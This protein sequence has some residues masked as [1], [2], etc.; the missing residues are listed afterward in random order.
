MKTC[1]AVIPAFNEKEGIGDVVAE[2]KRYVTDIIVVDDGST[3]G[4]DFLKIKEHAQVIHL[5][6]NHGKGAA[7]RRGF[8]EAL[9]KN[10]E[11]I[12]M[13][14]AD[15]EHDPTLIPALI[16]FAVGEGVDIVS[17]ARWE[18]RSDIRGILNNFMNFW[19]GIVTGYRITD[20]SCG[21]RVLK[22]EA[23]KRLEL[24]SN[25]FEIELEMLLD[26]SKRG[27]SYAEYPLKTK[28]LSESRV[29]V[30]DMIE[31]DLFF[32]K[33]VL[34]NR[35]RIRTGKHKKLFL[36]FFCI[37]GYIIFSILKEG[38]CRWRQVQQSS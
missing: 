14:D 23:L 3:D 20:S 38:T 22:T 17:C 35:A 13:L 28:T 16:D 25:G 9:K 7:L 26:A 36:L 2:T 5:G 12:V 32:D 34:E 4:T 10:R 33:W 37:L 11:Y 31:I 27:L 19:V 18:H 6:T 24:E 29:R 15:L 8:E 30:Y 21:Y 1:I